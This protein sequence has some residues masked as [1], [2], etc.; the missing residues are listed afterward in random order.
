MAAGI[1]L[2]ISDVLEEVSPGARFSEHVVT[3]TFRAGALIGLVAAF[4]LALA[5]TDLHVRQ[6]D[7]VGRGGLAVA[8]SAG[9]GVMLL[10]CLTW[11]TA[12]VDPAAAAVAPGFVDNT[13]PG[14][15]VIGYFGSVA[16]FGLSWLAYAIVL[17]RTGVLARPPLVLLLLGALAAALPVVPFAMVAFGIAVAWLG[18]APARVLGPRSQPQPQPAI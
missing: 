12:F 14:I 4:A 9:F 1:L 15:L 7:R 16:W 13:P 5:L 2:A 18:L 11:S 3:P 6:A 17:L 8:M 10:A